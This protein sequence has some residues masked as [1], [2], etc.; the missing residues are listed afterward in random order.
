MSG[1]YGKVVP[2]PAADFRSKVADILRLLKSS[3]EEHS[4]RC[5]DSYVLME[6]SRDMIKGLYDEVKNDTTEASV[7]DRI[8]DAMEVIESCAKMC[9]NHEDITAAAAAFYLHIPTLITSASSP[10]AMPGVSG[11]TVTPILA[12]RR[13]T[14]DSAK[15]VTFTMISHGEE[16]SR[17]DVVESKPKDLAPVVMKTSMIAR[18]Q[19]MNLDEVP[20]ITAQDASSKASNAAD[21]YLSEE[22]D[23][24][25]LD[26]INYE[27][28]EQLDTEKNDEEQSVIE[29][30]SGQQIAKL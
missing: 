4:R 16:P 2:D 24:T 18:M 17:R 13:D 22:Y 11:N 25:G 21:S 1:K 5:A 15:P 6:Q 26:G 29:L 30:F 8:E 3:T 28:G 10:I 14:S 19:R 9:K 7:L 12:T 27:I 23:L 20:K